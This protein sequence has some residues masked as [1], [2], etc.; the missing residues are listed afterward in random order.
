MGQVGA[1]VLPQAAG[2]SGAADRAA[3]AQ[4]S[5]AAAAAAA[6]SAARP[7]ITTH[8]LDT[9]LGRPAA[10][11][12]IELAR[13]EAGA[14]GAGEGGVWTEVGAGITNRCALS[15]GGEKVG[16]GKGCRGAL[17]FPSS[18]LTSLTRSRSESRPAA[19]GARWSIRPVCLCRR[20]PQM[21]RWL[22]FCLRILAIII[23]NPT[24]YDRAYKTLPRRPA[25][26]ACGLLAGRTCCRR[27]GRAAS[28]PRLWLCSPSATST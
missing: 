5:T 25:H 10:G 24:S 17:A 2:G 23:S 12:R 8:V 3:A 27:G 14:R 20:V 13:L 19:T 4:A 6:G 16:Q 9:S 11:I 18:S 15:I 7:P 26:T 22:L 1:H 28:T 21:L